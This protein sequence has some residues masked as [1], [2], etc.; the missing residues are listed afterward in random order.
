VFRER[1]TRSFEFWDMRDGKAEWDQAALAAN[2]N[3]GT[4][5]KYPLMV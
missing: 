4:S 3:V 2:V 1:L 5:K